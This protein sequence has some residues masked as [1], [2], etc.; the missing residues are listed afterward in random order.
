MFHPVPSYQAV[1]PVFLQYTAA[2]PLSA[3]PDERKLADYYAA[4]DRLVSS[5]K[6]RMGPR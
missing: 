2:L 1:R 5:W 4:R 6:Q 3:L